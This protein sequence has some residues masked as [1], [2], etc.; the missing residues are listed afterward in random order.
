MSFGK[1][2]YIAVPVVEAS[3]VS[4]TGD[5]SEKTQLFEGTE[6]IVLG[7][8]DGYK[9][10]RW[11]ILVSGQLMTIPTHQRDINALHIK[12]D[13]TLKLPAYQDVEL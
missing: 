4:A 6:V 3:I 8:P 10:I 5:D 13:K 12:V 9:F 11:I 7:R 1:V 2:M